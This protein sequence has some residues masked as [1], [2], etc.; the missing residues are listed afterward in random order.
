MLKS[1]LQQLEIQLSR[2]TFTGDLEVPE[3]AR[4][5]IVFA[6]GGE[7]G[8]KSARNHFVAEHLQHSGFATLLFDL[9]AEDETAGCGLRYKIDVLTE[10]LAAAV[11]AVSACE[12]VSQLPIGLFGVGTGAAA[13][14][15]L[16]A[17]RGPEVTA[18]VTASGRPDL[19]G[20]RIRNVQSPT[21]FLVGS[22]DGEGVQ[23][24]RTVLPLLPHATS[25]S[26]D[27]VQ[28]AS[29]KFEE[30]GALAHLTTLACGWFAA[31]TN[32]PIVRHW[33][34]QI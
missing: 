6:L 22:L 23:I 4:G 30:P 12:G 18:I 34:E 11:R 15:R 25:K 2:L 1:S 24:H 29:Q 9:I 10:R 5:L 7:G 21:L 31:Y 20:D 13:A 17:D 33:D 16:A 28:G 19:A 32:K 26:L 8:R 3:N 27:M 14:L